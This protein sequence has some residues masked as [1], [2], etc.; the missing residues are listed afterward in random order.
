MELMALTTDDPVHTRFRRLARACG[1]AGYTV[2]EAAELSKFLDAALKAPEPAIVQ[3]SHGRP[4]L[5]R[6]CLPANQE[7]NC[8]KG[9][10]SMGLIEEA[11]APWS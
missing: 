3:D 11:T 5:P 7:T 8:K 4:C 10:I 9:G 1:G 2:H 6:P